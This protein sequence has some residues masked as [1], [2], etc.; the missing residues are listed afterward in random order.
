M[1]TWVDGLKHSVQG[2][3]FWMTFAFFAIIFIAFKPLRK[4]LAA[5]GKGRS[6]EVRAKLDEPA[7]LR[8]EAEALLEKYEKHTKDKDKEYAQI[9]AETQAEIDFLQKDY[10]ELLKERLKRKDAE[11]QVRLQMIRDNGVKEMENQMLKMVVQRTY[12]LLAH[13]HNQEKDAVKEIDKALDN[14]YETLK[15][16]IHL[17]RK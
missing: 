17:V 3:E 10:D 11:T 4:Y 6:D 2:P 5:W 14:V 7:N 15:Q 1:D 16:N 13:H 12:D 9:M 8:K